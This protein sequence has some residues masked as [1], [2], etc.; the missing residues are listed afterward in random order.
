VVENAVEAA[1]RLPSIE[2]CA[3]VALL[4]AVVKPP[5]DPAVRAA[6]DRLR[7][8]LAEMRTLLHV[9]RLG[10]AMKAIAPLEQAARGTGYRA[11]LAET[12][13]EKGY[14]YA[15]R[16]EVESATR[17]YEE[18][19]WTAELVR[20]DEVAA[21]AATMLVGMTASQARFDVGDVWAKH[22]ETILSRMGGND[23]LWGWLFNNIGMMRHLQGRLAEALDYADRAMAAKEKAQGRESADLGISMSNKAFYLTEI[24]DLQQ[25]VEC[26]QRAIDILAAG[27]GPEHPR[28]AQALSN[29][30]ETLNL[31]GRFAEA[32]AVALRALTIFERETEP[33]GVYVTAALTALG[34]GHLDDGLA[35]EALPLLERA[36]VNRERNEI[37]AP[38]RLGEVHFALGRALWLT[39]RGR[40]RARALVV[41]A[42]D[43]YAAMTEFPATQKALDAID[44]WLATHPVAAM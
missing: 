3:D 28:T 19:I 44:T 27:F 33:D 1:T 5:D 12:L 15:E 43:E 39:D 6:V 26:G 31:L 20:H 2:R 25:A 29:Y 35:E 38:G 32:R 4:R 34:L 14:L 23:R 13:L 40:Q 24:G 21:E 42:R 10:D 7:G 18:A 16:R 17:T 22:A 8:Q 41:R 30:C 36:A 9:G 11:L 37:G